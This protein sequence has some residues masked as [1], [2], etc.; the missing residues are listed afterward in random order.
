M[1]VSKMSSLC[2][3]MRN[4]RGEGMAHQEPGRQQLSVATFLGMTA[5][6]LS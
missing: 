2:G 1:F 4:E 5:P 3:K 6:V